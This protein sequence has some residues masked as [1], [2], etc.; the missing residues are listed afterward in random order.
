MEVFRKTRIFSNKSVNVTPMLGRWRIL[1]R[2]Y[3]D[4]K[5][6]MANIDNC[7]TCYYTKDK[8]NID[9]NNKLSPNGLVKKD[10]INIY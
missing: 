4:R 3:N 1:N 2:E 9:I 7:G 10:H 5:I 8:G 6:D